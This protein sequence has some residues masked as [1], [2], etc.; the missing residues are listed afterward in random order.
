MGDRIFRPHCSGLQM[1]LPCGD[2]DRAS[3]SGALTSGLWNKVNY[4]FYVIT[5]VSSGEQHLL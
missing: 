1:S 4:K 3:D 2:N 5:R